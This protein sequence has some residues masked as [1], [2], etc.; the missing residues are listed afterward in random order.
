MN[1][2]ELLDI[3]VDA[4]ID[5]IKT[6]YK[7]L[8]LTY[9]P[10]RNIEKKNKDEYE[11]KFKLLSEAYQVLSN[12]ETRNKY[13]L[14]N[15]INVKDICQF[16]T[17]IDIFSSIFEDIP[18]EYINLSNK[19]VYELMTTNDMPS[20]LL[21]T[22]P[23]NS[24]IYGVVSILI[25]MFERNKVNENINICNKNTV[26]TDTIKKDTIKT[27][28]SVN[29]T[30]DNNLPITDN[31]TT[32]IYVKLEDIYN[33]E[34]KKIDINRIR[35]NNENEY[36]KERKTFIIPLN[37]S[38]VI[39]F[40]EADEIPNHRAGNIIINI[41]IQTH[42]IF[43][44]Y[45]KNDLYMEVELSLYEYYYGVIFS[46]MHLNGKII[47]I[48]SGKNVQKNSTK[49]IQNLGLPCENHLNNGNLYIKFILKLDDLDLNNKLTEQY[50]FSTFKPLNYHMDDLTNENERYTLNKTNDYNNTCS[51]SDDTCSQSIETDEL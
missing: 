35:K 4:T 36:K 30:V 43:K 10:D 1:Y 21:E 29:T 18:E 17:P 37:K 34:V 38:Q 15:N 45:R 32:T 12:D 47:T 25:K 16:E 14:N 27:Q 20:K 39:F 26:K 40:N 7:K 13:D 50:M 2:Y 49:K 19:F 33:K 48:D 8:A 42:K 6:S 51:Y 24:D 3:K 11:K 44:K 22:I 31:I 46:F 41:A 9:H 5:E 23:K 28:D